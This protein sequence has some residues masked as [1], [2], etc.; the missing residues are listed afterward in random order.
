M[1][2]LYKYENMLYT[3]SLSGQEIKDYLE[4]SYDLWT[5]TM[6]SSDD[7]VL[8]FRDDAKGEDMTHVGFKYPSYNFDSAA[9]IKYTVDVTKPRGEKITILSMA[10]GSAFD[11]NATY[12]VA[13]NSYR[14]NGG[15][16]ILTEGAGIAKEEL[17][18]RIVASTD[19]DLRYYLMQ[20]IISH[21]EV[22]ATK[23]DNWKFIPKEIVEPAIARDRKL[24]FN[25]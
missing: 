8:R 23:M 21:P 12:K 10:N 15:G 19:K 1:F 9:G 3:M 20:Y 2:N 13:I 25:D 22:N 18:K 17:S 6:Q 5:N 7:H 24:L 11:F 4:M 14:G 16:N